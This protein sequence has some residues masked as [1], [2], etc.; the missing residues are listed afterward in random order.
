MTDGDASSLRRD[1]V[2]RSFLRA[3]HLMSADMLAGVAAEHAAALDARE[4]V[5][6]LVDYEQVSSCRCRERACR[7]GRR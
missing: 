1:Q 6:Y 7:P 3:S 4:L 2:L 5:V